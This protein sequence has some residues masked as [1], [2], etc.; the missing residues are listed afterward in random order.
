LFEQLE[1]AGRI[2]HHDFGSYTG[3]KAVFK[4]ALIDPQELEKRYWQMYER[5]FSWRSMFR[6]LVPAHT[7][8]GL[9]MRAV[10]WAANVRY[11]RHVKS[12]ISPGIL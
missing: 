1:Q 3:S 12:R 9:Y 7:S 10:V 8:P 4:P 11:R 2:V 5:L 6:R